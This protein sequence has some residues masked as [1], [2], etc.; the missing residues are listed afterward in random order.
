MLFKQIVHSVSN[1]RRSTC[2][3]VHGGLSLGRIAY[4][5][6][7]LV[8]FDIDG[9]TVIRGRVTVVW[10]GEEE[11][12]S[13]VEVGVSRPKSRIASADVVDE[14]VYMDG[15]LLWI[16]RVVPPALE[17][18]EEERELLR[19]AEEVLLDGVCAVSVFVVEPE[20]RLAELELTVVSAVIPTNNEPRDG[21]DDKSDWGPEDELGFSFQR[22]NYLMMG[23]KKML[24]AMDDLEQ[25]PSVRVAPRLSS[26]SD[27]SPI[28]ELLE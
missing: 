25:F 4:S 19:E 3:L 9:A 22:R 11:M 17:L 26:S 28:L 27:D 24:E 1:V 12:D 7:W 15:V 13:V 8:P 6:G 10:A 20:V 5:L 21:T 23:S 18:L 16:A 14:P 2:I